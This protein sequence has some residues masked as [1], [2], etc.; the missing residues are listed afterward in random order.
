MSDVILHHYTLSP[1]AEKA[2]LALGLKRI[3][4]LGVKTPFMLPKPDLTPLTGGYRRAPVLQI[5]ADIY[6]DTSLILRELERRKP[7]PSLWPRDTEGLAT[8]M[9]WWIEKATFM[10]AVNVA[11][12]MALAKM[13]PAFIEDR[14]KFFGGSFEPETMEAQRP[15]NLAQLRAHWAALIAILD[16]GRRFLLGDAPSAADLAAYHPIFFLRRN[17]GEEAVR[18]E[19]LVALTPWAERV[20]GIGHGSSREITGAEALAI[21]KAATPQSCPFGVD[22]HEPHGLK[23]GERI[24][25][26]PDDSGRDDV[27]GTLV[28]SSPRQIVIRRQTPELGD[29]NVHFPRAGFVVRR[30]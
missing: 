24:A 3:D 4:W 18:I 20:A 22:R 10:P 23:E 6:C 28:A 1:F 2:R 5:G 11:S 7:L 15:H 9:S 16:H 26:T 17:L 29:I 30:V 21:A 14:R 25:V 13:P 19:E 8:A 12:S 27:V